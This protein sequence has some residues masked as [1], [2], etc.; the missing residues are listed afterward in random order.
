VGARARSVEGSSGTAIGYAGIQERGRRLRRG[1]P[2]DRGGARD[3][4]AAA[5]DRRGT[6]ASRSIRTGGCEPED[7]G[8]ANQAA[9]WRLKE[10][11]AHSDRRL[12]LVIQAPPWEEL[13]DPAPF[14]R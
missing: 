7:E 3:S 10:G 5:L 12:R 14:S 8:G 13:P 2:R 9:S 1:S 4:R 11:G 6:W